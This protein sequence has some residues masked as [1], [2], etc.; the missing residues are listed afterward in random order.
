MKEEK[1]KELSKWHE[2]KLNRQ[3]TKKKLFF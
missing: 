2:K 3:R 1:K